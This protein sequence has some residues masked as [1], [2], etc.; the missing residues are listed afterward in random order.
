MSP[1]RPTFQ[2]P[3]LVRLFTTPKIANP[4]GGDLWK[5]GGDPGGEIPGEPIMNAS[6]KAAIIGFL[7]IAALITVSVGALVSQPATAMRIGSSH[8]INVATYP[9]GYPLCHDL[10]RYWMAPIRYTG[11]TSKGHQHQ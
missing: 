1:T 9:E 7:L 8:P 4:T 3:A 11:E 2:N 5:Q 10:R 6:M